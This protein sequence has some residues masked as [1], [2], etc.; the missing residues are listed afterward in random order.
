MSQSKVRYYTYKS[1]Y[2]EQNWKNLTPSIHI[3]EIPTS[4]DKSD[5]DGEPPKPSEEFNP[6]FRIMIPAFTTSI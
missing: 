4:L 2:N 5:S 1:L 6:K 3:S